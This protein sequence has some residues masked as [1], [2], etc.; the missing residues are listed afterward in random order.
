[1][2]G[3]MA[4]WLITLATIGLL[5]V[6]NALMPVSYSGNAMA[7]A[8]VSMLYLGFFFHTYGLRSLSYFACMQE[9]NKALHEHATH[10][11]LT[12]VLNAR[13]YYAICEKDIIHSIRKREPFS[14]LLIDLDHFKSVNY[15]HG[16]D[17]GDVVLRAIAQCIEGTTRRSDVVG[18][19]GGEEFS[20]FLREQIIKW[21]C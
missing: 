7:T 13:A 21:R 9:H 11:V 12:G 14:V 16:H 18:R 10:D 1:M 17:A 5:I 19:I 20:V 6:S 2:F 4:G 3:P 15:T 8:I